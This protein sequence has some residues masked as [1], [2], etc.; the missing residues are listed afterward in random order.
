M[1]HPP[2]PTPLHISSLINN[3]QPYTPTPGIPVGMEASLHPFMEVPLHSSLPNISPSMQVQPNHQLIPSINH[4][5]QYHITPPNQLRTFQFPAL[6]Q[7]Q[8][9]PYQNNNFITRMNNLNFNSCLIPAPN[10]N[11]AKPEELDLY[12]CS[13]PFYIPIKTEPICSFMV[14]PLETDRTECYLHFDVASD[15]PVVLR[16]FQLRVNNTPLSTSSPHCS[17][18]C[19]G[20][21]LTLKEGL[22]DIKPFCRNGKN[23]V[24]Y[25]YFKTPPLTDY[26]CVIQY[27]HKQSVEHLL[28]GINE[29][30]YECGKVIAISSF[31]THVDIVETAHI[32]SMLDIYGRSVIKYPCRSALCVHINVFD[33]KI[34]LSFNEKEKKWSCPICSK[35]LSLHDLYIDG[36]FKKIFEGLSDGG[37]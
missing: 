24:S 15:L 16:C 4:L 2:T 3:S 35:I 18:K 19:N 5:N 1:A 8:P 20:I 9:L 14:N 17:F 30:D 26:Y 7:N 31:D 29:I 37:K 13:D 11:P 10:V 6:D 22:V 33:V 34:W 25:N 28:S 21:R 32:V 36:F 12:S 27:M 23:I